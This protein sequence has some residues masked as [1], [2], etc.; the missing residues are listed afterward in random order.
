MARKVQDYKIFG[1]HAFYTPGFSG[2]F[3]LLGW[4]IL[5]SIIGS[6]LAAVLTKFGMGDYAFM[7]AYAVTFIPPMMFAAA[8]GVRNAGFDT[9]YILDNNNFAPMKGWVLAILVMFGTLATSYISDFFTSLLPPMPD[10][11]KQALERLTMDGPLWV[12]FLTVSIMAP[13]FEEWLCRGMVLRGLLHFKHTVRVTTPTEEEASAGVKPGDVVT[14]HG[15]KPAWAIVISA[16]FFAVLHMNPWQGIAAFLLGCIFGYVYW[17]TGSL[18]LTMLMHF[19]N[20]TFALIL[21]NCFPSFAESDSIMDVLP[22]YKYAK[23][24]VICLV[25]LAVFFLVFRKVKVRDIH[26][27]CDPVEAALPE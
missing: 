4:F 22:G 19:T 15:L 10:F 11:L 14:R 12:S 27:N 6:V 1:N 5:G 26:G 2:M 24:A 18:K 9:G 7:V 23:G 13:F 16:L 17:K 25:I 8:R 20:N 3:A 21:A